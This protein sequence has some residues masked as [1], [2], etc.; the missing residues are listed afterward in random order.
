MVVRFWAAR[1]K[2]WKTLDSVSMYVDSLAAEW[3]VTSKLASRAPSAE[4][5]VDG[6]CSNRTVAS[7]LICGPTNLTELQFDSSKEML[8]LVIALVQA[9]SQSRRVV[10]PN[11]RSRMWSSNCSSASSCNRRSLTCCRDE[12]AA[13]ARRSKRRSR[14]ESSMYFWSSSRRRWMDETGRLSTSTPSR[15]W[16]QPI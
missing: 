13:I 7:G 16:D 11:E 3:K 15:M 8:K 5:L 10:L 4:R 12:N 14:F 9:G 2:S 1:K 6:A